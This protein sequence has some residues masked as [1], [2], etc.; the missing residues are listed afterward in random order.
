VK[1]VLSYSP[2]EALV[3]L[4]SLLLLA[5]ATLLT[6][7]FGA[8]LPNFSAQEVAWRVIECSAR[9]V[10][11]A[12]CANGS[13]RVARWRKRA[14]LTGVLGFSKCVCPDLKLTTSAAVRPDA[15]YAYEI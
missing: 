15:G 6:E 7:I 14:L 4:L 9:V 3:F 11:L 8:R 2:P 10:V 1:R 13:A 12:Q 5:P